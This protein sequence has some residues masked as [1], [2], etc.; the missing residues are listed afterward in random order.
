MAYRYV[1]ASRRGKAEPARLVARVSQEDLVASAYEHYGFE[2]P[3]ALEYLRFAGY[4]VT[5]NW[6]AMMA[7]EGMP[8]DEIARLQKT[9][10][11]AG[12]IAG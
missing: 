10:A 12:A 9:F 2:E 11:F 5:A 7:E 8:A 1:P 4:Q 6:K 3:E